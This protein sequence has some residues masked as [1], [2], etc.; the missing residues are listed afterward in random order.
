M[1]EF[2]YFAAYNL[3]VR[4]EINEVVATVT[5]SWILEI[6]SKFSAESVN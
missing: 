1:L 6:N 3:I 5:L 2:W 4:V